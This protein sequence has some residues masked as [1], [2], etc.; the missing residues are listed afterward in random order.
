MPR[1][2]QNFDSFIVQSFALRLTAL[3]RE[4]GITQAQAAASVGIT[5]NQWQRYE[6]GATMPTVETLV[7]IAD[8]FGVSVDYLLGRSSTPALDLNEYRAAR[9]DFSPSEKNA[10]A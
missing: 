9:A 4:K 6:Y 3:R 1:K 5:S 8:Y 2:K 7:N 10:I